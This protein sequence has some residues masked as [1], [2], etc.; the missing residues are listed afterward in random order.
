MSSSHAVS[1]AN[2]LANFSEAERLGGHVENY[3]HRV[4][5]ARKSQILIS[6]L[7]EESRRAQPKRRAAHHV[8]N[9]VVTANLRIDRESGELLIVIEKKFALDDTR[10]QGR[11]L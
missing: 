5:C 6:A 7:R 9:L 1:I 2:H 3:R 10:E 8:E 4:G 11:A